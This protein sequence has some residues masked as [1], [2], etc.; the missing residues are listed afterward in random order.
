MLEHM[1]D[2]LLFIIIGKYVC[3]TINL[4]IL[5]DL[6]CVGTKRWRSHQPQ[7][8]MKSSQSNPWSMPRRMSLLVRRDV[9]EKVL[10]KHG[11][12]LKL[13]VPHNQTR[14]EDP[15]TMEFSGYGYGYGMGYLIS[16]WATMATSQLYN[17][18]PLNISQQKHPRTGTS[19]IEHIPPG[20]CQFNC[21]P[22]RNKKEG[23]L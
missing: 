23:S 17:P 12:F 16:K 5:L 3:L 21:C 15:Q 10:A 19:W 11:K 9:P 4:P 14:L 6:I 8:I 18:I 7:T 20:L 22:F 1:V 13:E 2:L